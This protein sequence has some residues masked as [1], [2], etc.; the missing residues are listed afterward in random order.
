MHRPIL[1]LLTIALLSGCASR[2]PDSIA[3]S[4]SADRDVRGVVL[5]AAEEKLAISRF[6]AFFENVTADSVREQTRSLYAED[7]FFNDTL[8]TIR[9]RQAIEDYLAKTA[10]HVDLFHTE[11]VDVARSG[12]NYY[13]RWIMDVR[14]RG[15]KKTIRT[16]GISQ[17]RFDQTGRIVL[18]QDFWD[19]TSGFFEHLPLVGPLIR[20]VK[21]ML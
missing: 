18:H 4:L 1:T 8:K 17:L 7:A 19:S 10:T 2:S 11:V 5:S 13:A 12:D 14:F 21:S 20:G 15:S 9:G 3:E 6:K 16:I